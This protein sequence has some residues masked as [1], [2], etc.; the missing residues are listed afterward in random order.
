MSDESLIRAFEAGLVELGAA[1]AIR[2]DVVGFFVARGVPPELAAAL[3]PLAAD[4]LVAYRA[5]V[6]GRLRDLIDEFL[7]FTCA[8][9]GAPRLRAEVARFIAEVA[10]RTPY[11]RA[12]TGE[13]VAWAARTWPED[14]TLPPFLVDLARHEW[15]EAEVFDAIAGGEAPLGGPIALD[16]PVQ[17]DGTTSLRRYAWAVHEATSTLDPAA[18]PTTLLLYRDRETLRVRTLELTPRATAVCERLLAGEALQPALVGACAE[19]GVAL[20]DEFLAAMASFFADLAERQV[21][22]GAL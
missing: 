6:H 2:A 8:R 9:L 19:V 20:D 10:P 17:F 13:F 15:S 7:P 3:P 18:E 5:M 21:M 1:D 14:D 12:V 4:R 22:L 11:F 16:R